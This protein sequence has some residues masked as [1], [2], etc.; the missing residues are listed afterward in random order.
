MRAIVVDEFIQ[1]VTD[2][3][4][5][6]ANSGKSVEIGRLCLVRDNSDCVRQH[7]YPSANPCINAEAPKRFAP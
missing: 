7:K 4:S 5:A 2:V 3:F 6:S 1:L